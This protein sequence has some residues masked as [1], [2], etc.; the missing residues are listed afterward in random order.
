MIKYSGGYLPLS[1]RYLYINAKFVNDEDCI[2]LKN[3]ILFGYASRFMNWATLVDAGDNLT[4][5]LWF[6]RILTGIFTGMLC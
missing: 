6:E 5:K 1:S 3:Y 4:N 2:E